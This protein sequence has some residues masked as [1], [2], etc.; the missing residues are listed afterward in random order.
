MYLHTGIPV[1]GAVWGGL[2]GMDLLEELQ[3]WGWYALRLY[4]PTLH[5]IFFLCFLL[6]FEDVSSQCPAPVTVPALC[7]HVCLL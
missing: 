2:S 3:N 5:L 7:W 6:A 1:D 4:S